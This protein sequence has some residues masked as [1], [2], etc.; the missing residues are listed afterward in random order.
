MSEGL[1]PN[2]AAIYEVYNEIIWQWNAGH[3]KEDEAIARIG[4]LSAKDDQGVIWC[5]SPFDGEWYRQSYDGTTLERADPP[6]AG[7]RSVTP[8]DVS[9]NQDAFNPYAHL[10]TSPVDLPDQGLVGSTFVPTPP[11]PVKSQAAWR[12]W[13]RP[14]IAALIIAALA[15]YAYSYVT[16]E[17]DPSSSSERPAF[18]SQP[19]KP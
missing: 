13:I 12:G 6:R 15:A 2:L 9:G 16:Q 3:L 7:M 18:P 19:A 10:Q 8:F 1:H 11:A 14:F 5:I 4:E 17:T